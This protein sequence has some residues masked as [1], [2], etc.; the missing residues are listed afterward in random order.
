[1]TNNKRSGVIEQQSFKI[2]KSKS[3]IDEIDCLIAKILNLSD[4]DLDFY[5]NYDIKYRMGQGIED[6]DD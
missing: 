5:I 3:I 4:V 6:S 2:S 1:V